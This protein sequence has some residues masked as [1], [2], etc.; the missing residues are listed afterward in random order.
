MNLKT[1]VGIDKIAGI[2]K[3]FKPVMSSSLSTSASLLDPEGPLAEKVHSNAIK[4]ANV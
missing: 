3:Y 2:L 4:L 1:G